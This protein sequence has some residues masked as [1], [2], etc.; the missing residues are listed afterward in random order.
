MP[1]QAEGDMEK[2]KQTLGQKATNTGKQSPNQQQSRRTSITFTRASPKTTVAS[3]N[4]TA[5][6]CCCKQEVGLNK[7][8]QIQNGKS[9]CP[10]QARIKFK[11]TT[12]TKT[13]THYTLRVSLLFCS[14]ALL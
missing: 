12:Q 8:E 10:G 7:F 5:A 4:T 6:L 2:E 11:L 14:A 1:Q 3:L 9:N 13:Q